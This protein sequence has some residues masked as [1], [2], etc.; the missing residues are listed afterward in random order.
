MKEIS[1]LHILT[2]IRGRVK[3]VAFLSCVLCLS[4]QPVLAQSLSDTA[5][6]DRQIVAQQ[7][8]EKRVPGT[9]RYESQYSMTK[10]GKGNYHS[11]YE[12]QKKEWFCC[13]D[14]FSSEDESPAKADQ[15]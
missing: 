8:V 6:S 2:M 10:D 1:I 15:S 7:R 12:S 11:I 3:A 5:Q 9:Y 13:L 4:A 14:W